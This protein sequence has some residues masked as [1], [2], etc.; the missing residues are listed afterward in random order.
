[1][2]TAEIPAV[3]TSALARMPHVYCIKTCPC[4]LTVMCFVYTLCEETFSAQYV[5]SCQEPAPPSLSGMKVQTGSRYVS[6]CQ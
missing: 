4:F 2:I 6:S 1:M 3:I 5:V